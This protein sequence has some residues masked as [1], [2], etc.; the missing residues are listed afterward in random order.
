VVHM[1][2]YFIME[3]D[4]TECDND[5]KNGKRRI[6]PPFYF[7]KNIF[8]YFLIVKVAGVTLVIHVTRTPLA[9]RNQTEKNYEITNFK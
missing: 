5:W 7:F 8:I 9:R 1:R 3:D 2:K 6:L 4:C